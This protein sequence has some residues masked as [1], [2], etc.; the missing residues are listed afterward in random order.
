[1]RHLWS[2]VEGAGGKNLPPRCN[3]AAVADERDED[4][5]LEAEGRLHEPPVHH[6]AAD[7]RH[8]V[9]AQQHRRAA[10]AAS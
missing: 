10:P 5:H 8:E 9:Q 6:D 4:G 2:D 7:R 3:D 1:M